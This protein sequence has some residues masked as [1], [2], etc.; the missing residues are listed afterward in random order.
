VNDLN[1][2]VAKDLLEAFGE[3]AVP[4]ADQRDVVSEESIDQ[5]GEV[6]RDLGHERLGWIR[7]DAGQLDAGL[8]VED[9]GLG[10]NATALVIRQ[11]ERPALHLLLQD[12]ILLAQAL[13]HLGLTAADPAGE[14]EKEQAKRVNRGH[15][16]SF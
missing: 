4:V 3:F 16:A 8:P 7:S 11:T 1:A 9:L 5:G 10:R 13:D 15:G 2:G 6:P 14:A 12:S